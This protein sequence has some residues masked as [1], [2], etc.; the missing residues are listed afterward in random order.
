MHYQKAGSREIPP[1][2]RCQETKLNGQPCGSMTVPGHKYCHI[3][4]RFRDLDGA[5]TIDVPLLEDEDSLLIVYSQTARSLAQGRIPA[6]FANGI[7]RA[8]R[9]AER[10]LMMKL[11]REELEERRLARAEAAAKSGNPSGN[12]I[13]QPEPA[14]L[15][16]TPPTEI[17]NDSSGAGAGAPYKPGVGLCGRG[18]VGLCGRGEV[19]LCGRGEVGLCGPEGAP[20]E[21]NSSPAS[22]DMED[23][24]AAEVPDDPHP[25]TIPPDKRQVSPVQFPWVREDFDDDIAR[26]E[27]KWMDMYLAKNRAMRERGIVPPDCL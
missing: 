26:M 14:E 23:M 10:V 19:G 7:L 2:R 3:H 25:W 24:S 21:S 17:I 1:D 4:G 6:A 11:R 15:L 18:D 9:G 27:G 16:A 20:T 5:S 22:G 12:Q 8:C 13:P